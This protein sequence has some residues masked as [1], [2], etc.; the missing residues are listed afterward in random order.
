DSQQSIINMFEDFTFDNTI[1]EE[2]NNS[3]DLSIVYKFYT[4][5]E[6]Y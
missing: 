4:F 6:K 1:I 5:F 3:V 2:F